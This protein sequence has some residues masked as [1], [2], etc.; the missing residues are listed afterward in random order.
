MGNS[1]TSSH[2]KYKMLI[3]LI[4]LFTIIPIIELAILIKLGAAIGIGKTLFIVILTGITGA[5]LTKIQGLQI[6]YKVRDEVNSGRVPASY[7]FDG[8]LIF[9]AGVLLITPGLLTDVM[10]FLML[11]PYT[12]QVLKQQLAR[13]VKDKI[14][15]GEV[16]I[17]LFG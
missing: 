16:R 5:L 3:K 1:L 14:N 11:V 2:N 7:L 15:K 12:R 17:N 4:L 10:G 8:F 6:L 13:I 9:I